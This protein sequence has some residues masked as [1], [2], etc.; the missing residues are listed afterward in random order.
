M[1]SDH[2]PAPEEQKDTGSVW[3]GYSGI[4][5]TRTL[6]PY[7][8]S[9]GY[10]KKRLNL[11]RFLQV[12]AENAARRYGLYGKKGSI[13]IGK[14]ADLVI[15]EPEEKWT[16]RGKDLYSKG[17]ITPFEGMEWEGRVKKT[18]L[19]GKVIY[20]DNKGIL[21][22]PGYGK[23]RYLGTE[24]DLMVGYKVNDIVDI[25]CGYSHMFAGETMELLKSGNKNEANYWGWLMIGFSP[26][27]IN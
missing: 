17:K 4:P 26:V 8:F 21:A 27:F 24:L 20:D 16:V 22:E 6:L 3:T 9:E 7:L 18:I 19:R 1:A 5:G 25:S 11:K 15:I 23:D 2:A 10:A 14:D 12:T 13:T